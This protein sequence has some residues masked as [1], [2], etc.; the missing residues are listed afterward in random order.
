MCFVFFDI[1]DLLFGVVPLIL[2]WL[3]NSGAVRNTGA[4]ICSGNY[5]DNKNI[6]VYGLQL[7]QNK[8]RP[9][10]SKHFFNTFQKRR[11]K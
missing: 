9:A 2:E 3:V 7:F 4:A 5:Y 10:E 1:F 11:D 6:T 8:I